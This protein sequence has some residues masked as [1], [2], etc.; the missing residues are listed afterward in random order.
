MSD[1]SNGSPLRPK[2]G[3]EGVV[4]VSIRHSVCARDLRLVGLERH[5]S[6]SDIACTPSQTRPVL[7]DTLM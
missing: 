5:W 6:I 7:H 1:L 3:V 4:L 2:N